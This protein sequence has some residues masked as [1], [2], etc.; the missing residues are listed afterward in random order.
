MDR[1]KYYGFKIGVLPGLRVV[2]DRSE[3]KTN[4]EKKMYLSY[5]S[6]IIICSSPVST[7]IPAGR[8]LALT[9]KATYKYRSFV[10]VK[11]CLKVLCNLRQILKNRYESI[12]KDCAFLY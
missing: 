9:I 6:S 5:I 2:H 8:L 12:S 10:P 11:N 1:T 4:I 3:R 7:G